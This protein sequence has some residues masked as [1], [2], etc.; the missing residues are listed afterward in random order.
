MKTVFRFEDGLYKKISVEDQLKARIT[1]L[2]KENT[3]IL[4]NN[5]NMSFKVNELESEINILNE[6]IANIKAE[7]EE[8][9]N[10]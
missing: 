9:E 7:L 2:E 5:A 6:V 1:Q 3:E 4:E 10:Q 8:W